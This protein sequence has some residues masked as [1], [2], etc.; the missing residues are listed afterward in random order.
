MSEALSG[1]RLRRQ[2]SVTS[3]TGAVLTQLSDAHGLEVTHEKVPEKT[4]PTLF[5][6]LKFHDPPGVKPNLF[7]GFPTFAKNVGRQ[8]SV[9][10]CHRAK[11]D[12]G[13]PARPSPRSARRPVAPL[14]P[15][16]G[17][18]AI[19]AA[20]PPGNRQS[21]FAVS[22]RRAPSP[23]SPASQGRADTRARFAF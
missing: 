3:P 15:M 2:R 21:A 23:F 14:S 10:R 6:S 16:G 12:S 19:A 20:K 13:P 8:N 1:A 17:L 9:W 18:A 7:D 22:G 4:L 5:S 11:A